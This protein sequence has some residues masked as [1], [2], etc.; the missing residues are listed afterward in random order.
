MPYDSHLPEFVETL[1]P[2]PGVPVGSRFKLVDGTRYLLM[3]EDGW[4]IATTDDAVMGELH[5]SVALGNPDWFSTD[6]P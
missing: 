4:N 5:R 2:L 6:N 1:Q 3:D